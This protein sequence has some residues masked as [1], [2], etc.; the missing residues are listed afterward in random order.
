MPRTSEGLIATLLRA[1]RGSCS[2][3]YVTAPAGAT[4]LHAY[5]VQ[6]ITG[7]GEQCSVAL[8]NGQKV[9]VVTWRA[10]TAQRKKVQLSLQ[11]R[12]I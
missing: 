3:A 1:R 8:P 12:P 11:L 9:V 10:A 2:R 4:V 6:R 5:L 7:A